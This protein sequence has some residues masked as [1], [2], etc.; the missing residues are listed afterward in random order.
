MP[1]AADLAEVAAMAAVLAR[2]QPAAVAGTAA[3]LLPVRPAV[4]EATAVLTTGITRRGAGA[5]INNYK[6]LK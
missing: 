3:V 4:A 6:H 2:A 1:P 5:C